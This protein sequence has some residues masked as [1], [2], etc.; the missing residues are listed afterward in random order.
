[1]YKVRKTLY[2]LYH[3]I[4]HLNMFGGAYQGQAL[5]M[6]EQLLAEV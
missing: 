6:T 3:I 5:S 4:N 1:G 2:N